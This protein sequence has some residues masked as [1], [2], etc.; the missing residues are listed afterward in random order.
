MSRTGYVLTYV[1]CTVLWC[2]KLHSEI[3]LSTT[4]TEYIALIQEM[5]KV[6]PIMALI[7]EVYFIL[8]IH[9]PKAEVFCKVFEDNQGCID[10]ADSK[11]YHQE[12]NLLLLSI[13]FNE[14]L[15]KEKCFEYAI[16]I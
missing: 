4:E 3:Y 13:I 8:D 5:L 11:K 10:V 14:A 2:S 6:I 9:L 16:L 12:Q 7:K 1:L 15:Y